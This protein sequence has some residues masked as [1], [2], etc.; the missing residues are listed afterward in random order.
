MKE[1][2]TPQGWKINAGMMQ[3]AIYVTPSHP[4]GDLRWM[5]A[6][7]VHGLSKPL[8]NQNMKNPI[9]INAMVAQTKTIAEVKGMLKKD[10]PH[11]A[12]EALG[13]SYA[14]IMG[15]GHSD[16]KLMT[17]WSEILMSNDFRGV[18]AMESL[19][20]KYRMPFS[21]MVHRLNDLHDR[22]QKEPHLVML[23]RKL[24]SAFGSQLKF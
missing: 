3:P 5:N 10:V 1:T 19:A 17:I 11:R 18:Q 8:M 6:S 7:N 16:D 2:P 24:E 15:P 14:R 13:V 9:Q 20:K 4:D 23:A 21:E 22:F 12:A